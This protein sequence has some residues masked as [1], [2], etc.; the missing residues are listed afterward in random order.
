MD[1]EPYRWLLLQPSVRVRLNCRVCMRRE[2][3]R[4]SFLPA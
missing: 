1:K 3:M 4:G 2:G